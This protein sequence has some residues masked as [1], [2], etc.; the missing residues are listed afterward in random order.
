VRALFGVLLAGGALAACWGLFQWATAA[1]IFDVRTVRVLGLSRIQREEL[2]RLSPIRVGDNI[3]TAELDG[4][5]RALTR[6]PWVKR[7]R[8]RRELPNAVSIQV[9]EREAAALIDLGG[10]YLVDADGEVFKRA[11][12]GDGLDL[13]VITG[14]TRDDY[15]QRR[16]DVDPLL[17]GALALVK[18]YGRA[19]L[20]ALAPLSEIAIH[21]DQ[22]VTLYVGDDATE[23][24]MGTGDLTGKLARLAEVLAALDLPGSPSKG[25]KVQALYLDNRTRPSWVTVRLAG[26]S[27]VVT[28]R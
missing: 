11:A 22:G 1:G 13:P 9:E 4:A 5:E 7:A 21:A 10:L 2:L 14:L 3:W 6:H 20:A 28:A 23:V 24:R 12:P 19:G 27:G 16:R 26:E 18:E 8:V 17:D 25:Q 15:V